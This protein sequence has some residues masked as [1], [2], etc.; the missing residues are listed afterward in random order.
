[1]WKVVCKLGLILI[2]SVMMAG[3]AA[4]SPVQG[5]EPKDVQVF[6]IA[7]G[8]I[9]K[10]VKNSPKIREE[11]KKSLQSI[12]ELE[13]KFR[14][15]PKDGVVLRIPMEPSVHVDNQWFHDNANEVFIIVPRSEKPL[16]LL[17]TNDKKP[18]ILK[19]KH[20]VQTLLKEM[21]L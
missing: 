16:M 19:F 20:P 18:I 11:V 12:H 15:E 5:A 13:V 2:L 1:M 4:G 3:A 8:K 6:D 21:K 10:R 14:V 9:V 7:Q 17:F